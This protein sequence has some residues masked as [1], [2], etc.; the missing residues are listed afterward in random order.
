[1]VEYSHTRIEY[2]PFRHREAQDP[3]YP[4]IF[5]LD[6]EPIPLKFVPCFKDLVRPKPIHGTSVKVTVGPVDEDTDDGEQ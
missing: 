3:D 6:G 4:N 2:A 5:V 1:M